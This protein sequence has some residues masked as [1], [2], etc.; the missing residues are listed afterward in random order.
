MIALL[1]HVLTLTMVYVGI[2]ETAS[3][4]TVTSLI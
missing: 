4:I 2:R 3:E 1:I